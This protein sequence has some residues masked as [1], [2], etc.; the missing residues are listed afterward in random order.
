MAIHIRHQDTIWLITVK[1]EWKIQLANFAG[2]HTILHNILPQQQGRS[3]IRKIPLQRK[4]S[5]Q[6][7]S[8]SAPRVV[9]KRGIMQ[10]LTMNE[11]L[12]RYRNKITHG[13]YKQALKPIFFRSDPELIHDR[14]TRVGIFLGRHKALRKII[15][16]MFG[17]QNEILNQR[18][19]GINFINPIGLAAGLD[20]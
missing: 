20:C 9:I 13:L 3:R 15:G 10:A 11:T 18:I 1:K 19:L 2:G 17:Y 8:S 14:M 12:I 4:I 16:G 5:P 7:N 6:C